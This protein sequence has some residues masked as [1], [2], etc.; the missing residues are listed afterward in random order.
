LFN[1]AVAASQ[2]D[3]CLSGNW[4]PLPLG[5]L[6]VIAC[7]KAAMAMAKAAHD[8]YGD[9]ATGLIIVPETHRENA[10]QPDGFELLFA[11]HPVPDDSSVAAAHAA[12]ELAGKLG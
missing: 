11:S 3:H 6:Q 10:S 4:P 12:L 9:K 5:E 2:A 1:T 8:H 7:G